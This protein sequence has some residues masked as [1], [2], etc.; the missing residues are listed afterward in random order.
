MSEENNFSASKYLENL[1]WLISPIDGT[2][3][4]LSGGEQFTVNISLIRNGFPI[5]GMIAHPP[6]KKHLVFKRDKL[7]ILNK[8]SFKK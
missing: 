6:T 5:M 3:S 7:I 2:K 1:Y 4:Y 8:N